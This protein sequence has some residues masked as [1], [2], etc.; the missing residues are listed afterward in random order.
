MIQ[1][2]NKSIENRTVIRTVIARLAL[3]K[4]YPEGIQR[5]AVS[6]NRTVIAR[7]ALAKVYPEG[8]RREATKIEPSLRGTKQSPHQ[9]EVHYNQNEI[10]KLHEYLKAVPQANY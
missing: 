5:E 4:V 10:Q 9:G 7:L 6:K 1:I 3:A 2:L 8:T